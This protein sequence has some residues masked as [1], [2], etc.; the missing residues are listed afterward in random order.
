M[1]SVNIKLQ[2]KFLAFL[3]FTL[4][5]VAGCGGGGDGGGGGGGG[6]GTIKLGW[7]P[8]NES[9]LAGYRVYYG[10]SS[11]V[12]DNSVDAGKGTPSGGLITYTLTN[13]AKGLTYCIA[14]TAYNTSYNES[15]FS[16]E[17]CGTAN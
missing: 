7:E 14:V 13:L 6:E 2:V 12:Y 9:D 11:L 15:G 5:L 3:I 1:K 17:V 4:L 16:N 8:N 10:T